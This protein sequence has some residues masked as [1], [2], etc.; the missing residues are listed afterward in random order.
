MK[1]VINVW[2]TVLFL[3][4]FFFSNCIVLIHQLATR[5]WLLAGYFAWSALGVGKT[6][7]EVSHLT[8]CRTLHSVKLN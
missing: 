8:K 6:V 5:L 2:S 4:F 3:F 7:S 1:Y